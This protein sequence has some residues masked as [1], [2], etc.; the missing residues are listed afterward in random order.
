M[1]AVDVT[2]PLGEQG[3]K[4]PRAVRLLLDAPKAGKVAEAAGFGTAVDFRV[5]RRIRG[6]RKRRWRGWAKTLIFIGPGVAVQGYDC[7]R[8][9]SFTMR[10]RKFFLGSAV[11]RG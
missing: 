4:A 9:G 10:V 5:Q 2:V 3:F 6:E 8:D 11:V 1:R 7:H